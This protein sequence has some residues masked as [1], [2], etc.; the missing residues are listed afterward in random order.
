MPK[1]TPSKILFRKARV[2]AKELSNNPHLGVEG[3]FVFGSV[4]ANLAT[5]K[6]DIDVLISVKE[7][8]GAV[9]KVIGDL[10][11][12]FDKRKGVEIGYCVQE[13]SIV[14]REVKDVI[15]GSNS[16]SERNTLG[17]IL[18][19][20]CVP[21]YL[22]DAFLGKVGLTRKQL[23][24]LLRPRPAIFMKKLIARKRN[25]RVRLEKNKKKNSRRFV[26]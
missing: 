4:A 26:A 2:L 22:N 12:D 10:L 13:S 3:V 16:L 7:N 25:L 1:E 5:E 9:E 23:I 14:A 6:S 17:M 8:K 18:R 15:K 24:S 19:G 11:R 20:G 21:L